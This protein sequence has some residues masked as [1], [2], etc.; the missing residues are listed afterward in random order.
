M[1][2]GTAVNVVAVLSGGIGTL[3]VARFP[4]AM[5]RIAVRVTSIVTLL[6]GVQ[7]YLAL[8]TAPIHIVPTLTLVA[9]Q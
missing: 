2:I 4:E 9:E 8:P 5:R 3:V 1:G 7:S 6:V